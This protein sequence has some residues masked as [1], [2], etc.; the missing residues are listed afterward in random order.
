MKQKQQKQKQKE[1]LEER[2]INFY[3]IWLSNSFNDLTKIECIINCHW[4]ERLREILLPND[5]FKNS[6]LDKETIK[7][8]SF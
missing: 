8:N 5:D 1:R 4:K 2:I 6:Y 7:K 3:L